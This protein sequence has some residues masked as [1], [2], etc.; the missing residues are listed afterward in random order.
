MM[1]V[2]GI[3]DF[4]YL[5]FQEEGPIRFPW[6]FSD[7]L[8]R[9]RLLY[10]KAQFHLLTN[11]DEEV[12][13]FTVHYRPDMP[14][15]YQARFHLFGLLD[16]PAMHLDMDIYLIRPFTSS[17]LSGKE[18]FKFFTW[19]SH[20]MRLY[21]PLPK[22]FS[23]HYNGGMIWLRY[24]GQ[25]LCREFSELAATRFPRVSLDDIV[26]SYYCHEHG[27]EFENHPRVNRLVFVDTPP[28]PSAQSL[29]FIGPNKDHLRSFLEAM[30][31]APRNASFLVS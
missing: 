8:A 22:E 10:P 27:F 9:V 26:M 6:Y 1:H 14:N 24:A 19:V 18:P 12:P 30:K 21:K 28:D 13:G 31:D 3:R 17:Q 2:E 20:W 25:R 4:V 11:V 29:H 16:R 15:S 23:R 5:H 7:T